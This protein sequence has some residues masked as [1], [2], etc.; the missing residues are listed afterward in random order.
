MLLNTLWKIIIKSIGLWLL[1]NSIWVI[2]Q[3]SSTLYF[4]EGEINW[5][6]L[7]LVWLMSS[8][9]LII[10]ILVIRLFL[11]KTEWVVKI[12]RLDKNFTEE[13]IGL[14]IPSKTVLSITVTIIGAIW[15]L[16]SFPNL[17][18]SIFDFLRQKELIYNYNEIGMLIYF[19]IATI[20]GYLIMTNSKFVANYILKENADLDKP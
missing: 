6:N 2:P 19:F 16:M 20:S 10:Y 15:F 5:E 8:T 13:K 4:I 18:S 14:D 9:T 7:T 1:I 3:F 11:F 12:L 17:I